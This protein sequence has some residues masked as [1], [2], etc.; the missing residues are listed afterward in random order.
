MT[1][2]TEQVLFGANFLLGSMAFVWMTYAASRRWHE[3]PHEVKLLHTMSSLL[4]GG[5]L[6][7][8]AQRILVSEG[9]IFDGVVVFLVKVSVLC[10]LWRVRKTLYRTG[11][12]HDGSKGGL[13]EGMRNRDNDNPDQDIDGYND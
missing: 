1:L 6:I 4:L 10:I 9:A 3:F 8:S 13:D 12:R 7:V 2:G 5:L 11:K